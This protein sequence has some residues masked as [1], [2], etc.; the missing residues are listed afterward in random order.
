MLLAI[1]ARVGCS[2]KLPEEIKRKP[3]DD[4]MEPYGL[5]N[6]WTQP[7]MA[8]NHPKESARYVCE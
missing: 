7:D 3:G 5:A 2:G 8:R 4:H 6:T 1:T